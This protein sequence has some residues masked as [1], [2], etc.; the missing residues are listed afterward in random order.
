MDMDGFK[1]MKPAVFEEYAK[2]GKKSESIRTL[3]KLLKK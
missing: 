1:R 2:V 3:L